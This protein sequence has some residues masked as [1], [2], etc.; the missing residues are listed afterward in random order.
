[1]AFNFPNTPTDGQNFVPVVGGPVYAW[2]A[3]TGAWMITSGGL[4]AGVYIGDLPPANPAIGQLWWNSTTGLTFIWF[5][6]GNTSQ[7]VQFNTGP[8]PAV[9]TTPFV[10]TLIVNSTSTFQ[11]NVQTTYADIEVLGAGGGGGGSGGSS[12]AGLI[13]GGSC[14]GAGGYARKVIQITDP[15]RAATKTIT[16]GV[17]GNSGVGS[18]GGT[19]GNSSYTDGTNTLTGN[20]GT[21]G[22]VGTFTSTTSV[23]GGGSG[24]TASGG[25]INVTGQRG[26]AGVGIG[27]TTYAVAGACAAWSGKGGN[28]QYGAGGQGG[29]AGGNTAA[30][31]IP[32]QSG[33]GYGS[34]GGGG[35]CINAVAAN[36][37][38][39]S[40]GQGLC[41]ITEYR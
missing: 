28:S 17:A 9:I 40:G 18:A 25:D 24:G 38:G 10:R 33:Q 4:S 7:W 37:A 23:F 8:A 6:D 36:V 30:V 41:I 35:T 12:G 15:I 5:N 39:G 27:T 26:D 19:G 3:A 29:Q 21:G 2:S 31:Q 20:G 14:G 1:M 16:I 22:Q 32:G 11:F 13:S 34:G